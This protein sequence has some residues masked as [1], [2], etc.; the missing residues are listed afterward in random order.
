METAPTESWEPNVASFP[1]SELS[2]FML[3]A[4]K[5]P[6]WEYVYHEIKQ[7]RKSVPFS[8]L[9]REWVVQHLPVHH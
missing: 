2:D 6:W 9:F 3:S 8:F 7:Y 1:N 5:Q 4:W